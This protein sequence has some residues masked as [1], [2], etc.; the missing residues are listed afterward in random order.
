MFSLHTSVVPST[1][2][3]SIRMVESEEFL[4]EIHSQLSASDKHM[5][6]EALR[7]YLLDPGEERL[8][9][10]SW[11]LSEMNIVIKNRDVQRVVIDCG[12]CPPSNPGI[13]LG[14][15][16]AEDNFDFWKRLFHTLKMYQ[17]AKPTMSASRYDSIFKFWLEISA[18]PALKDILQFGKKR[19]ILPLKVPENS[20]TNMSVEQLL[21]EKVLEEH[22]LREMQ[23]EEEAYQ[24]TDDEGEHCNTGAQDTEIDKLKEQLKIFKNDMASSFM[25]WILDVPENSEFD[26]TI[27][28]YQNLPAKWRKCKQ[29]VKMQAR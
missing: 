4:Q 16:S 21:K 3:T 23:K 29:F 12:L 20:D 9:L 8:Q 26:S 15:C 10:I 6:K 11:A 24:P 28:R 13:V 1:L 7:N 27:K 22:K 18:D 2:F 19:D 14:K 17:E 25:P 5:D